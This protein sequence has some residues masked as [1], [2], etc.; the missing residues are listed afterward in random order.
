[1]NNVCFI[2]NISKS[3]F[4]ENSISFSK[5]TKNTHYIWNYVSFIV[6]LLEKDHNEYNGIESYIAQKYSNKETDWLPFQVTGMLKNR[7]ITEEEARDLKISR[8]E[9]KIDE[10]RLSLQPKDN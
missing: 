6:G 7:T 1:M 4:T 9:Q 10:L 2:C 8:I 3:E 5:H